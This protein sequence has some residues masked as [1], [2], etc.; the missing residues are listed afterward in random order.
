M[1][2]RGLE[3]DMLSDGAESKMA[4]PYILSSFTAIL[5]Q[6]GGSCVGSTERRVSIRSSASK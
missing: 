5:G 6:S 2:T 1:R 3:V 4:P